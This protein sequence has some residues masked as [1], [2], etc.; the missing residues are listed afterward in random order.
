MDAPIA[1]AVV[2]A[3]NPTRLAARSNADAGNDVGESAQSSELHGGFTSHSA[4]GVARM[5][6]SICIGRRAAFLRGR[7]ARERLPSGAQAVRGRRSYGARVAPER[8]GTA[9][10]TCNASPLDAE[11]QAKSRWRRHTGTLTRC[12]RS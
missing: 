5:G 7:E 4:S 6:L 2:V 1:C 3:A 10:S 9:N 8:H 11:Q 12:V